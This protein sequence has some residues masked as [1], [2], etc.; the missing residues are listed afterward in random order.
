MTN[1]SY[2]ETQNRI[3]VVNTMDE[4]W[5]DWPNPIG[6]WTGLGNYFNTQVG[7]GL[8]FS[9]QTQFGLG[10]GQGLDNPNIPWRFNTFYN[11]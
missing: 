1:N 11:I 2:Q 10:L 4:T 9:T 3:E 8:S 6:F 5:P 7:V